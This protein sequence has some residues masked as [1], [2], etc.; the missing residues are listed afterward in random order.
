MEKQSLWWCYQLTNALL[1]EEKSTNALKYYAIFATNLQA[2]FICQGLYHHKKTSLINSFCSL[3]ESNFPFLARSKKIK[4]MLE[5]ETK[6]YFNSVKSK[7]G[8]ETFCLQFYYL[9]IKLLTKQI[10]DYITINQLIHKTNSLS[11]INSV[12]CNFMIYQLNDF[13]NN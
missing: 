9:L 7:Y 13:E 10:K 5:V 12:N 3:I 2:Y 1:L 6:N 11:T 8:Y 4:K